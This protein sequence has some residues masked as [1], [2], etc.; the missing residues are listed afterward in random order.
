M[1]K[2]IHLRNTN[3]LLHLLSVRKLLTGF[4]YF[5]RALVFIG[6]QR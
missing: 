5:H 6:L 2:L 3:K 4:D 1:F